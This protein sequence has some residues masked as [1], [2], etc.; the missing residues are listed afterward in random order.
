MAKT[1]TIDGVLTVPIPFGR[2]LGLLLFDGTVVVDE[3]ENVLVLRVY[4]SLSPCI[5]RTKVALK[6]DV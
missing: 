4:F 5:A 3:D 6:L 1:W 2:I